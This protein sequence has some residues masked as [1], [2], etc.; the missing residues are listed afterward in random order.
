M[1]SFQHN[2]VQES[3]NLR[4][5]SQVMN[6]L[7][8][9]SRGYEFSIFRRQVPMTGPEHAI[10]ADCAAHHWTALGPACRGDKEALQQTLC[11]P[12]QV[13]RQRQIDVDE[14]IGRLEA[15]PGALDAAEAVDD[16]RI[17]GQQLG[18]SGSRVTSASFLA[19][20]DFPPPAFP[21]TATFCTLR[22]DAA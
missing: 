3:V 9:P 22:F 11:H 10:A 7:A 13:P 18:W 20:A 17:A 12:E 1:P 6:A 19:S 21:K 5:R 2:P 16:P 14:R 15:L 4:R 8:L